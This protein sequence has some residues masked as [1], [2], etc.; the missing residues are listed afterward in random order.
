MKV[1]LGHPTSGIAYFDV[2]ALPF[3]ATASVSAFLRLSASIAFIGVVASKIC[4]TV[5]FDD[6]SVVCP[7]KQA[8]PVQ[9]SWSQI[10][11]RWRQSSAVRLGVQDLG[12]TVGRFVLERGLLQNRSH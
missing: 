2:L 6:Y 1:A 7:R 10:C 5:F 3:G 9:A 8:K 12:L 4:W 11:S